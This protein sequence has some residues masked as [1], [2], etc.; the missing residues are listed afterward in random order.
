MLKIDR[1]ITELQSGDGGGLRLSAKQL[2]ELRH[3]MASYALAS[4][5]DSSIRKEVEEVC[6]QYAEEEKREDNAKV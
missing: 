4:M 3:A 2:D 6:Q 5:M 1:V